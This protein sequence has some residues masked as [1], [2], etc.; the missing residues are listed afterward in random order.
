MKNDLENE[1][2][3]FAKIGARRAKQIGQVTTNIAIMYGGLQR[4]VGQSKLPE[5]E[6]LQLPEGDDISSIKK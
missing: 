2:R 1:P 3:A 4:I 5:I 6:C